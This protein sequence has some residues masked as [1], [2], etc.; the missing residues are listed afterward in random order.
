LNDIALRPG[1]H[2]NTIGPKFEDTHELSPRVAE[3][4]A[5]VATDSLAQVDAYPR[6][7]FLAGTPARERMVELGEIVAGRRPGRTSPDDVTLFCSVGLAG[8]EVVLA[9]AALMLAR[10]A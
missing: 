8:T 5:I 1:T 9:D 6:P 3:K 7:F 4:S 10:L 2:V